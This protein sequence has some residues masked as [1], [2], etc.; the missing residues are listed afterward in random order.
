MT[1]YSSIRS[2]F[3]TGVN[4]DHSS[5]V[6]TDEVRSSQMVETPNFM[7]CMRDVIVSSNGATT[8]PSF[9]QSSLL[10][11]ATAGNCQIDVAGAMPL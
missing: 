11:N 4:P 7:G 5:H 3:I 8:K 9:I 6:Y 1:A 2:T 10:V